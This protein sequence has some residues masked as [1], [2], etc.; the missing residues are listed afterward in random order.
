MN[1]RAEQRLLDPKP[2]W[3]WPRVS[4]ASHHTSVYYWIHCIYFYIQFSKKR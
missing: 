2:A 3:D 1:H 4:V